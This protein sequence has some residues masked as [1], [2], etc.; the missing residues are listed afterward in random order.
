[1]PTGQVVATFKVSDV[2]SVG[3]LQLCFRSRSSFG[4]A[5][6]WNFYGSRFGLSVVRVD[7]VGLARAFTRQVFGLSVTGANLLSG[8]KLSIAAD[9]ANSLVNGCYSG[10]SLNYIASISASGPTA[11]TVAGLKALAAASSIRVCWGSSVAPSTAG[12]WYDTGLTIDVRDLTA[13][14]LYWL[15]PRALE[16]SATVGSKALAAQA[17]RVRFGGYAL[18][19][20]DRLLVYAG[21]ADCKTASAGNR[22]GVT[23]ETVMGSYE[24]AYITLPAS[25]VYTA[26]AEPV[27]DTPQQLSVCY[28]PEGMVDADVPSS[29]AGAWGQTALFAWHPTDCLDGAAGATSSTAV[30]SSALG[31]RRLLFARG[32]PQVGFVSGCTKSGDV[33]GMRLGSETC[34]AS[35]L[36]VWGLT[37]TQR[38]VQTIA[39]GSFP[40][41]LPT[42]RSDAPATG[43]QLCLATRGGTTLNTDVNSAQSYSTVGGTGAIA[44]GTGAWAGPTAFAK[45][46]W[47]MAGATMPVDA[48]FTTA[49]T[50]L[51]EEYRLAV[52]ALTDD[53]CAIRSLDTNLP[54]A[55]TD[56]LSP[57]DADA[58]IRQE[59]S[60]LRISVP[61]SSD[62]GASRVLTWCARVSGN[63]VGAAALVSS[64]RL[65]PT[66]TINQH[67]LLRRFPADVHVLTN[68]QDRTGLITYDGYTA[69]DRVAYSTQVGIDGECHPDAFALR[70]SVALASGALSFQRFD[71]FALQLSSQ[72]Q[73]NNRLCITRPGDAR[74][75]LMPDEATTVLTTRPT[76]T[77]AGLPSAIYATGVLD[78]SITGGVVYLG[79]RFSVSTSSA[80]CTGTAQAFDV[81]FDYGYGAYVYGYTFNDTNAPPVGTSCLCVLRK[82]APTWT[83]YATA[84][85][86][87]RVER[88]YSGVTGTAADQ[89]ILV[90]T[91]ISYLRNGDHNTKDIRFRVTNW[92]ANDLVTFSWAENACR[93]V[94]APSALNVYPQTEQ[95]NFNQLLKA[96]GNE[97][98]RKFTD[99][100]T[101]G[102][103]YTLCYM[104]CADPSCAGGTW[105]ATL[106][107]L[108]VVRITTAVLFPSTIV[109]SESANLYISGEGIN[110]GDR[111]YITNGVSCTANRQTDPAPTAKTTITGVD[112]AVMAL[113]PV[114]A[115][116]QRPVLFA[117]LPADSTPCVAP[118][119]VTSV[120]YIPDGV[121]QHEAAPYAFFAQALGTRTPGAAD[122]PTF[123]AQPGQVD[124][125]GKIRFASGVLTTFKI[126][127]LASGTAGDGHQIKLIPS[128]STD[129]TASAAAGTTVGT[130]S[131]IN[132]YGEVAQITLSALA[133]STAALSTF[134]LCYRASTSGSVA[135]RL[136]PGIQATATSITGFSPSYLI[137][138]RVDVSTVTLTLTSA[139][140]ALVN[141]GSQ[142]TLCIVPAGS[143]A[144]DNCYTTPATAGSYPVG[145]DGT[146]LL[147]LADFATWALG[148]QDIYF[149]PG[150]ALADGTLTPKRSAPARPTL[151]GAGANFNILSVS[152]KPTQVTTTTSPGDAKRSILFAV[153]EASTQGNLVFLS[154][155][156]TCAGAAAAA[157]SVATSPLNRADFAFS[158]AGV[159]TTCFRSG[160]ETASPVTDAQ[161]VRLGGQAVVTAVGTVSVSVTPSRVQSGIAETLTVTGTVQGS[162]ALQGGDKVRV[163]AFSASQPKTCAAQGST[164]A[165]PNDSIVPD[166]PVLQDSVREA[167]V[168]GLV[169]P[170]SDGPLPVCY[171]AASPASETWRS[172]AN[173]V[174]LT[175]VTATGFTPTATVAGGAETVMI[176]GQNLDTGDFAAMVDTRWGDC[177]KSW[178]YESAVTGAAQGQVSARFVLPSGL[179]NLCYWVQGSSS[180]YRLYSGPGFPKLRVLGLAGGKIGS[181]F[182]T[183]AQPVVFKLTSDRENVEFDDRDLFAFVP[184]A[185]T[186]CSSGHVGGFPLNI[187]R[188]P[189]APP[190]PGGGPEGPAL[191]RH[192]A[193]IRA[194]L[195]AFAGG[196]LD[197]PTE[198]RL[199]ANLWGGFNYNSSTLTPEQR[200]TRGVPSDG[201][202]VFAI[203]K[204]GAVSPRSVILGQ[205][206]VPAL[207]ISGTNLVPGD[208]VGFRD[209]SSSIC[210][211]LDLAY[212]VGADPSLAATPAEA[213]RVRVDNL[214]GFLR[215]NQ[216]N[217]C[218]RYTRPNSTFNPEAFTTHSTRVAVVDVASINPQGG[219]SGVAA[220]L[221][222]T[223]FF[224][225]DVAPADDWAALVPKYEADGF[226]RVTNC[227]AAVATA[228]RALAVSSTGLSATSVFNVTVAPGEYRVCVHFAGTPWTRAPSA[229][230]GPG[231][232]ENDFF[233][234]RPEIEY[235]SRL[236]TRFDPPTA[237]NGTVTTVQ[238]MGFGLRTGDFAVLINATGTVADC[239]GSASISSNLMRVTAFAVPNLPIFRGLSPN[240]LA[241]GSPNHGFFN[242]TEALLPQ[243]GSFR[244]C[245]SFGFPASAASWQLVPGG[246][247]NPS[248]VLTVAPYAAQAQLRARFLVPQ[249]GLGSLAVNPPEAAALREAIPRARPVRVSLSGPGLRA[250]DL[251]R[252]ALVPRSVAFSVGLNNSNATTALAQACAS[253]RGS[254]WQ[255][256]AARAQ[257]NWVDFVV[258]G[259]EVPEA[260]DAVICLRSSAGGLAA[261]GAAYAGLPGNQTIRFVDEPQLL[262]LA[263][264]R[265]A[266]A[267]L[268][269]QTV[270]AMTLNM[271]ATGNHSLGIVATAAATCPATAAAASVAPSQLFPLAFV[272]A[273]GPAA[274]AANSSSA[275]SAGSSLAGLQTL[276]AQVLIS[277]P[278]IY[279]ACLYHSGDLR[280]T[281]LLAVGAG[282][283]GT[284]PACGDGTRG[285]R[286]LCGCTCQTTPCTLD[287]QAQ[288]RSI[289]PTCAAR[290]LPGYVLCQATGVCS[291]RPRDCPVPPDSCPDTWVRCVGGTCVPTSAECPVVEAC[292]ADQIRCVDGS[293]STGS[294]SFG[295]DTPAPAITCAGDRAACALGVCPLS[296][297][298]CPAFNGCP[299]AAPF[300]C[301]NCRCAASRAA[302]PVGSCGGPFPVQCADG[303]CAASADGCRCLRNA[304][305]AN[306]LVS[307]SP[308]TAVRRRTAL[309][310]G[311]AVAAVAAAPPRHR[312]WRR[313][314]VRASTAVEVPLTP[315]LTVR[316]PAG[317]TAS[318]LCSLSLRPIPDSEVDRSAADFVATPAQLALTVTTPSA[319]VTQSKCLLS[320]GL[321]IDLVYAAHDLNATAPLACGLVSTT[322][323]STVPL[324]TVSAA[325]DLFTCSINTTALI[326]SDTGTL[327]VYAGLT[328]TP[329]ALGLDRP[330]PS[331]TPIPSS[332]PIIAPS[333]TPI[334]S[335]S[336]K[337]TVKPTSG[338]AGLALEG[339]FVL[340]LLAILTALT[341]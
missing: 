31:Q 267:S 62:V 213:T 141:A 103:R 132:T 160:R 99:A 104:A 101:R 199:C 230:W 112:V 13:K 17:S 46:G 326:A 87:A 69:D 128:T 323:S 72:T 274:P 109:S 42:V 10:S 265:L 253:A 291:L 215:A 142:D 75:Y 164:T 263:P 311:G 79:D 16:A 325:R 250:G 159:Y 179:Y 170:A 60:T 290:G 198:Y 134:N 317:L 96:V 288:A 49:N 177:S 322:F 32:V 172:P 192:Q 154:S 136:M 162:Q 320:P 289:Q 149:Q 140:A 19:S 71:G 331:P 314:E 138:N 221:T 252:V 135:Y 67:P 5:R 339:V 302:C 94:P 88:T 106:R 258:L 174:A 89:A 256:V 24:T 59:N 305:F 270:V 9:P 301:G 207:T 158:S 25:Y 144:P 44:S 6:A 231:V 316:V 125:S 296:D 168:P 114:P 335:A 74:A 65:Y 246:P 76:L 327:S 227:S 315:A 208:Q 167:T 245:Y 27:A 150:G 165:T 117:T 30:I 38:G 153:S 237:A 235:A 147:A 216:W 324:L 184:K 40:R 273:S 218:Y 297:G 73:V 126:G 247:E 191:P 243:P 45:P 50:A 239:V 48:T 3:R 22:M 220:Q 241:Q 151:I 340:A 223:G 200:F 183:A 328:S 185:S 52:N 209:N 219:P 332:S 272:G 257:L 61:A 304:K 337:P 205:R 92:S 28:Y 292:E 2:Q 310:S 23:L 173:M 152:V 171:R 285:G 18:R 102:G 139:A 124:A 189:A 271:N 90:D 4:V 259:G 115:P 130:V 204:I 34:A 58:P 43:L 234:L 294:C 39:D 330:P 15:F 266:A 63:A 197:V 201:V 100:G 240:N 93:D 193:L 20:G 68:V 54:A 84:V 321:T 281:S 80:S 182:A 122:L 287:Q 228:Q 307:L 206:P 276:A 41:I 148:A 318:D 95:D 254:S 105:A 155:T 119:T 190:I 222:F 264:Q 157:V 308:T 131:K 21:V 85:R 110:A 29:Y 338:A 249:Q 319:N 278:G 98:K 286:F 56:L 8:D 146:V 169:L 196:S 64:W 14:S 248:G 238:V 36:D 275:P 293:C 70:Q 145:T 300:R 224:N 178:F 78:L 242:I 336:Q 47:F 309:S 26:G 11:G 107:S 123:S 262:G 341:A 121:K 312:A 143:P 284:V 118:C 260:G 57:Y 244:V 186:T 129:C 176:A 166:L 1:V 81:T 116:P 77:L 37:V 280:G 66:L 156:G 35:V 86:V 180:P 82:N 313:F 277:S 163:L 181:G 211:G 203:P 97:S 229:A 188:I 127:S 210:L 7:T 33:Y 51:T 226:T 187:T 251:A 83:P 261:A 268:G 161:F 299:P 255:P 295:L 202:K 120:C 217:L 55:E 175:V 279:R 108:T 298:A 329:V 283:N 214:Q 91:Y 133:G 303:S 212:T 334:P 137:R 233:L 195:T 53:D 194:N 232:P 113:A 306:Q 111:F 236:L 225:L 12:E 333:Y 282:C 269:F